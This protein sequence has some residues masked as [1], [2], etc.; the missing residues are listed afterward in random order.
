MDP[1]DLG[2]IKGLEKLGPYCNSCIV[3]LPGEVAE[4][5]PWEVEGLDVLVFVKVFGIG[6]LK[7]SEGSV[8]SLPVA[9]FGLVRKHAFLKPIGSRIA[10]ELWRVRL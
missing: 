4:G 9:V 6:T 7:S 2:R 8:N 3:I 10:Q 5:I 1:A